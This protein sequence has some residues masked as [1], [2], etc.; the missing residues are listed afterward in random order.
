M[1][2]TAIL[3]EIRLALGR[4]PL[5]R[6]FRNNVGLLRDAR[7]QPVRFGL[8]PGSGDLIGVRS[9]TITPDMVGRLIGVFASVEVKTSRGKPRPDQLTWLDFVQGAGGYAGIARCPTEAREI[10]GLPT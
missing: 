8:H 10:L 2:E 6:L 5:V 7:G 4:E 1:S 3:Q 9:I